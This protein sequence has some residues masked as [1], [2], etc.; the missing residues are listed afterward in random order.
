VV[1]GLFGCPAGTTCDTTTGDVNYG[2]CVATCT[3]SYDAGADGGSSGGCNAEFPE[4][5]GGSCT[6]CKPDMAGDP[7]CPKDTPDCN[8]QG[9]CGCVTSSDC[10]QTPTPTHCDPAGGVYGFGICASTCSNG[11]Q[12]NGELCVFDGGI[13]EGASDAGSCVACF[14]TMGCTA[15]QVCAS[16]TFTC[17]DQQDAGALDGGNDD[18][19]EGGGATTTDGGSGI[20]DSGATSEPDA[21]MHD[22]GESES[23]GPY[24]PGKV[25]GGGCSLFAVGAGG[26]SDSPVSPA[27]F[28]FAGLAGLFFLR[29]SRRRSSERRNERR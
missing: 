25:E 21:T 8:H 13:D 11:A 14:G 29:R 5:V 10:P 12:C 7:F 1:A 28:G 3:G 26:L 15:P 23:S 17:V 20:H 4:C 18:G 9:Y 27:F 19:G 16:A 24:P 22:G 2:A 6:E